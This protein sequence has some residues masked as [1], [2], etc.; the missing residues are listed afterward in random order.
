MA[1]SEEIFR[2]AGALPPDGRAELNGAVD[3]ESADD[4]AEITEAQLAEVRRRIT[5]VESEEVAL[6]P[7]NE[8]LARVRS[9]LAKNLPSR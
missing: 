1:T 8:V 9:L 3:C 7:G 2:D 4:V 6:I 5:Q